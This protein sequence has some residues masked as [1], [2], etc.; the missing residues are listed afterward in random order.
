MTGPLRP[1]EIALLEQ[2]LSFYGKAPH[3]WESIVR[4]HLPYRQPNV[5]APDFGCWG[6]LCGCMRMLAVMPAVVR[7]GSG[8]S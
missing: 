3:R 5:S 1:D 4:D 8:T 7:Y 2:A 6:M